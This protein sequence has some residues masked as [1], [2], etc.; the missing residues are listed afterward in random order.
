MRPA[1]DGEFSIRDLPSGAYRLAALTD[2]DEDDP[3]RREFLESI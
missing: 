2:V 1:T 3:K